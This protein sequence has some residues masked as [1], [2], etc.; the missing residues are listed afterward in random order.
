M[1]CLPDVCITRVEG[2]GGLHMYL[3]GQHLLKQGLVLL[4]LLSQGLIDC[5]LLCYHV[6][7]LLV[8][9]LQ[10]RPQGVVLPHH[11]PQDGVVVP[12]LSGLMFQ[13]TQK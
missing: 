8:Y 5:T 6:G 10:G 9:V 2:G 11:K 4:P 1:L 13:H 3:G 12:Y 7:Q